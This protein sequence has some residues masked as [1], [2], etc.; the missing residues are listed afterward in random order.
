VTPPG[1]RLI[2]AWRRAGPASAAVPNACSMWN[3]CPGYTP[4][5]N[6]SEGKVNGRNE[7]EIFDQESYL[8]P[9][10]CPKIKL[11]LPRLFVFDAFTF[12][13]PFLLFAPACRAL[14]CLIIAYPG[15]RCKAL[16]TRRGRFPDLQVSESQFHRWRIIALYVDRAG[17]LRDE[18][19]RRNSC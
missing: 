6:P 17:N 14:H 9:S 5:S 4:S 11:G 12:A 1:A 19:G 7:T 2:Y 13:Q 10:S 3:S 16:V 8:V 18:C 15:S